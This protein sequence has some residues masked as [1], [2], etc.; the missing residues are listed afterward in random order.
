M[1]A[2]VDEAYQR[3]KDILE[4]HHESLTTISE[5]LFGNESIDRD[6]FLALPDDAAAEDV[7]G[8]GPPAQKMPVARRVAA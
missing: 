7:F 6:Q 1:R 4:E 8:L 2:F 5:I 3:A